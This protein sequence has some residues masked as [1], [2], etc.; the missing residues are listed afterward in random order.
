MVEFCIAVVHVCDTCCLRCL[1]LSTETRSN[2]GLAK[3]TKGTNTPTAGRGGAWRPAACDL[4]SWKQ[5][6]Q[7]ISA[8]GDKE[9]IAR[10]SPAAD[11]F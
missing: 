7:N 1:L 4:N 3:Q 9:V 6:S 10:R 8:A 5:I 2:T 11:M